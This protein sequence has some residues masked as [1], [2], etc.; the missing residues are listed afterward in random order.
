MWK[1]I[2]FVDNFVENGSTMCIPWTW[3][4]QN[5]MQIFIYCTFILL[6]YRS[7]KF[8]SYMLIFWSILGSWAFYMIRSYQLGAHFYG[9]VVDFAT[10]GQYMGDVYVKPYA[11]C[12]PYLFGLFLGIMYSRFLEE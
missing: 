7:N 2:F 11:R 3:Y 9:H 10:T 4:L 6:V 8:G 12:A 1:S 5:D